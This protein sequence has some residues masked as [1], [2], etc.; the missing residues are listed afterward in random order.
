M[1]NY[2]PIIKLI[3][4]ISAG[5][6]T[7]AGVELSN[8]ENYTLPKS[9]W[10]KI[11]DDIDKYSPAILSGDIVVN[12]GNGDL[13]PAD[14]VEYLQILAIDSGAS[15]NFSYSEITNTTT[16]IVPPHQQMIVYQQVDVDGTLQLDG[17]LVVI[18]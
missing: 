5:Q 17:D 4:N 18:D 3:K 13:I 12:D 7:F 11:A 16:I 1:S 15:Y 14:A 10:A 2:I 6:Y 8:G 9:Q